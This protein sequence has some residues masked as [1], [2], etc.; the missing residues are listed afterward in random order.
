MASAIV[1][2]LTRIEETRGIALEFLRHNPSGV[3][4]VLWPADPDEAPDDRVRP[5][6]EVMGQSV[7]TLCPY[8]GRRDGEFGLPDP[9]DERVS[10]FADEALCARCHRALGPWQHKA[11]EHNTTEVP[12]VAA[13]KAVVVDHVMHCLGDPVDVYQVATGLNAGT[14]MLGTVLDDL[15]R[16]APTLGDDAKVY[17][18]RTSVHRPAETAERRGSRRRG[19]FR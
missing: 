13:I 6:A 11:F 2:L 10:V 14:K 18:D 15:R 5:W 19:G 4:H 8:E 3:V 16:Y 7:R 1:E 12:A 9:V 17:D